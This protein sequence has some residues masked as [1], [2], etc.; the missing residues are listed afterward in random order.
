[1]K[2]FFPPLPPPP[3]A[4]GRMITPP[5]LTPPTLQTLCTD[6]LL[7]F[8]EFHKFHPKLLKDVCKNVPSQ[9]LEPVLEKL[10]ESKKITDV[11]L[12]NF[13]NPG[14][15]TLN[16]QGTVQIR[17]ATY[18]QIGFNC[19]NLLFLDLSDCVQITNSVVRDVLQGCNLLR[20]LRLDR[21]H[22]ITD[23]AFDMCQSPFKPLVACASLESISLQVSL[24]P[25]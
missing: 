15:A 5:F 17:N 4:K 23:N 19:P 8:L 16:L 7:T 25:K 2:A 20:D 13:L 6:K 9:L 24:P 1:M 3:S 22:R 11:V 21:C 12:L 14:R 10:L 18:R